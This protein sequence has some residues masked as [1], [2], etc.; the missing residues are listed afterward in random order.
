MHITLNNVKSVE[1]SSPK[2][3]IGL[4]ES[5]YARHIV[6]TTDAGEICISV[7][8]ADKAQLEVLPRESHIKVN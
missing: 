7:M 8:S 4:D 3:L 5:F 6:I 2:T 1:I